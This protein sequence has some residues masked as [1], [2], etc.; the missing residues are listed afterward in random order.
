MLALKDM[1]PIASLFIPASTF[2][3]RSYYEWNHYTFDY[4]H[5]YLLQKIFKIKHQS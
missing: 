4:I 5:H 2:Y 3:F 1:F